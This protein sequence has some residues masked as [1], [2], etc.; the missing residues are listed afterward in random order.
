MLDIKLFEP[1]QNI[2]PYVPTQNETIMSTFV[3]QRIAEMQAGRV[4]VDRDWNIYQ[5]MID[6]IWTPYPD[7]RSSSTV[8]LAASIIELFVAEA[9]KIKT[10]FN[11]KAETR[12]H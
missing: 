5:T 10:E 7:E 9:T 3:K 1:N 6:A 12:K 4:V 2:D 8:P 11:F